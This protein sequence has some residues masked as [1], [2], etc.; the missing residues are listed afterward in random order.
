[1]AMVHE[2]DR[3][4]GLDL[5]LHTPGGE[6][7][8]VESIVHYLRQMFGDNIRAVVP[9]LAMSGGTM[10]ACACREIIMGKHSNLGPIDPQIGGIAAHGVLEE[11]ERAKLETKQDPDT[12]RVWRSILGQYHPAFIGECEK[13]I[14]W[15]KEIVQEWLITGM[16]ANEE[17]A[18]ERAKGV[19]E[20]LTDYAEMKTHSRHI[21]ME[22]CQEIGLK[23]VELE[24]AKDDLQD[25][26]LTVHH[27][28]MHTFA[29]TRA[30]KIVENHLGR[31]M[32]LHVRGE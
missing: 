22:R 19:V 32:I 12:E 9:Q 29:N 28:Y 17:N 4:K 5:L 15:A 10:I 7:S 23:V 16:F 1:M 6:L 2:L 11:F 13:A 24:R 14:V 18:E 8:A 26:V 3:K 21:H 27:S 30:V 31:A 25:K 20:A